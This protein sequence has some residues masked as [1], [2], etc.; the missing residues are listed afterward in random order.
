MKKKI[1]VNG[2]LYTFEFK[3]GKLVNQQEFNRLTMELRG[4]I[5]TRASRHMF[6]LHAIEGEDLLNFHLEKLWEALVA[7]KPAKGEAKL[8]ARKESFVP[9]FLHT[10]DMRIN[11]LYRSFN[12]VR[13]F[14]YIEKLKDDHKG[15]KE[16]LKNSLESTLAGFGADFNCIIDTQFEPKN[17]PT[18]QIEARIYLEQL[19]DGLKD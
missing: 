9:F 5:Y 8:E 12:K 10:L 11:D 19:A 15:T 18:A 7:Y 4:L 2:H 1:K 14:K 13:S 17:D 6:S 16:V 3:N